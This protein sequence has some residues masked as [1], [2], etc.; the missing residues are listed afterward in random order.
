LRRHPARNV[1]VELKNR[2]SGFFIPVV[3]HSKAHAL[4]STPLEVC[5]SLTHWNLNAYFT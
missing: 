4:R 3:E 5:E 1:L 2:Q